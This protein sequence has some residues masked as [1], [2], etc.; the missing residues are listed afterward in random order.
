MGPV[1]YVGKECRHTLLCHECHK[2]S[3][4]P[5]DQPRKV[6]MYKIEQENKNKGDLMSW[7]KRKLSPE[8]D[9][10]ISLT[11]KQSR[12]DSYKNK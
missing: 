4:K 5:S 6:S 12:S 2:S 7:V 10:D 9:A 11:A 1:V 3:A 8:K